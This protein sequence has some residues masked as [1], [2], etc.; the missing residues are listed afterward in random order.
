MRLLR[1]CGLIWVSRACVRW[2]ALSSD[3]QYVMRIQCTFDLRCFHCV[4]GLSGHHP[5]LSPGRSVLLFSSCCWWRHG[6]AGRARAIRNRCTWRPSLLLFSR[7]ETTNQDSQGPRE[8][9]YVHSLAVM[10]GT[11]FPSSRIF[12]NHHIFLS[13]PSTSTCLNYYVPHLLFAS[14]PCGPSCLS[15]ISKQSGLKG[16]LDFLTPLLTASHG[17]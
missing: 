9:Y 7:G 5:P 1:T 3:V 6:D 17:S 16:R 4:L 11:A 13:L 10:L 14:S 8:Q 2:A 12:I 15:P